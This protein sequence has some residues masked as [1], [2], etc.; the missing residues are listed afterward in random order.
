MESVIT[1]QSKTVYGIFEGLL[2]RQSKELSYRGFNERK[3]QLP[4]PVGLKPWE[5]RQLSLRSPELGVRGLPRMILTESNLTSVETD[6]MA[7]MGCHSREGK[8]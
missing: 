6:D 5:H 8:E 7:S 3:I 2:D 1:I 4:S